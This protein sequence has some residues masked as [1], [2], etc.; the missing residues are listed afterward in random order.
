MSA[1]VVAEIRPSGL[2]RAFAVGVTG[3]LGALLALL[4]IVARPEP[5]GVAFLLVM[6][7]G[8]LWSAWRVWQATATVLELTGE[9][10]REAGGR[11]L[12]RLDEIARID[13]GFFAFKP[14]SGFLVHLKARQPAAMAP[15]LWWRLGRRVAVG[16]VP[17]GREAKG[18]ADV[19]Q[20]MLAERGG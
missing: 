8:A 16:G 2:R 6:A 20:I 19:M 12:C 17:R 1:E 18:V 7:A 13:R 14:A 9:E 11:T 10:L 5:L 15:G 4:V 3:V